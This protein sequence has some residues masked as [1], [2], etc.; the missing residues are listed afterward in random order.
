VDRVLADVRGGYVS[1]AAAQDDYGVVV[2][3]QDEEFVLD[4]AATE[5]HRQSRRPAAKLFHNG[6]Y[7]EAME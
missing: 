4:A 3:R 2:R 5:T 1:P 6:Q 7:V